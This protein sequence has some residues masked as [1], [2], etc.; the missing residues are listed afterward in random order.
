METVERHRS[1]SLKCQD[2]K[3]K[4]NVAKVSVVGAGMQTNP[5]V[6]ARMFEALYDANVNIQQI[7]TSEIRVTVLID[8]AETDKAMNAVHK[9]FDF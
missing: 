5:G 9:E 4:K 7:S 2:V 8:R 3:V 6:A 1:G